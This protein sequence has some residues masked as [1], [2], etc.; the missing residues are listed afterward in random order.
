MESIKFTND[1]QSST[2][3]LKRS[4]ATLLGVIDDAGQTL[5]GEHHLALSN[6]AKQMHDDTCALREGVEKYD[7]ALD[8]EDIIEMSM[9]DEEEDYTARVLAQDLPVDLRKVCNW[10]ARSCKFSGQ[11]FY[12]WPE[13]QLLDEDAYINDEDLDA[14]MAQICARFKIHVPI[15]SECGGEPLTEYDMAMIRSTK[16]SVQEF[17]LD[18]FHLVEFMTYNDMDTNEIYSVGGIRNPKRFSKHMLKCAPK[19]LRLYCTPMGDSIAE[20]ARELHDV[21]ALL[22]NTNSCVAQLLEDPR[23][24]W[25]GQ[26]SESYEDEW[27]CVSTMGND[28]SERVAGFGGQNGL[29][30]KHP[31]FKLICQRCNDQYP[32]SSRKQT[33]KYDVRMDMC[34]NLYD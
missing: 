17:V 26:D 31:R 18:F 23:K 3:K 25:E 30:K 15:D 11:I 1:V 33:M 12:L 9:R 20:I 24:T 19:L 13:Q 10:F 21:L 8:D 22:K 5:S 6:L 32:T 14:L 27:V 29:Y 7:R 16:I 34:F 4:L 28:R 2:K